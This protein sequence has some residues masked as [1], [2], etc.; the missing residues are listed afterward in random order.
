MCVPPRACLG[1]RYNDL[2]NIDKL[3]KVRAQVNA[4]A[5]IMQDNLSLM[6]DRG[7]RVDSLHDKAQDLNRSAEQFD[8]SAG[9][10]KRIFC[11]RKHES[12]L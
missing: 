5:G 10:I 11:M 3:A 6:M 2:R 9:K 7:D 1:I 12:R 8:K 4:V